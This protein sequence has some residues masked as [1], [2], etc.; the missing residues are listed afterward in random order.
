MHYSIPQG[1]KLSVPY[2][3]YEKKCNEEK[4]VRYSNGVWM[5]IDDY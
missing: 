1:L 4:M 3:R 2:G 5:K